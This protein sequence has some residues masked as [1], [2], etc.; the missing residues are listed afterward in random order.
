MELGLDAE[1][2]GGLAT[3]VTIMPLGTGDVRIDWAQV[4]QSWRSRCRTGRTD[5]EET[6]DGL[7]DGD[8]VLVV[9]ARRWGG[10]KRKDINEGTSGAR[11]EG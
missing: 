1:P 3:L 2:F 4:L 7:Q 11:C 8:L 10:A 6:V 5:G 9:R